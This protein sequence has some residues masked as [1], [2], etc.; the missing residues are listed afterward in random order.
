MAGGKSQADK[1]EDLQQAVAA[2]N[3]RV[4]NI[5][6]QYTS[7]VNSLKEANDSLTKCRTDHDMLIS[8]LK[9]D[10]EDLEKWKDR[11][12]RE[13]DKAKEETQKIRS[14]R[15]VAIFAFVGSLIVMVLNVVITY[16]L[17]PK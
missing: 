11:I 6:K 16:L 14:S 12:E 5:S 3:E 13:N 1:I 8:H 15:N 17:R 2:I 9:R 10:I 4:E 7:L